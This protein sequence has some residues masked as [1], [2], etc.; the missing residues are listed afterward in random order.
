MSWER[1][2]IETLFSSKTLA[3]FTLVSTR[4][5][6]CGETLTRFSNSL[7]GMEGWGLEDIA[8]AVVRSHGVLPILVANG[9]EANQND[10]SS[11]NKDS[12]DTPC[13]LA[14]LK[15]G[16]SVKGNPATR[17]LYGSKH[18]KLAP[19]GWDLAST[20]LEWPKQPSRHPTQ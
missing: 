9:P 7:L 15:I 19:V 8:A 12:G 11:R 16:A 17:G 14:L 4:G 10:F 18:H 6:T 13:L 5:A 2:Q 1:T 20:F 3:L